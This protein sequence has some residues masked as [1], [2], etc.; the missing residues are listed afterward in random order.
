MDYE[1]LIRL[2]IHQVIIKKFLYI[3]LNISKICHI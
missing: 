1:R 3:L 2:K